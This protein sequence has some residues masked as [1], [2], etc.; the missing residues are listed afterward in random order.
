M[1]NTVSEITNDHPAPP[2]APDALVSLVTVEI[3]REMA[4]I[5]GA[6]D[7]SLSSI[8]AELHGTLG[9]LLS[10]LGSY[11]LEIRN[12]SSQMYGIQADHIEA[13]DVRVDTLEE[14]GGETQILPV[15]AELLQK[16]I[17]ACEYMASE[18]I[19]G[20]I[21]ERDAEGKEKLGE[22]LSLCGEAQKVVDDATLTFDADFPEALGED[23][24]LP[25]DVN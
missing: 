15:D 8:H 4:R 2:A 11:L 5:K 18:M 21:S 25:G 14:F 19:K 7:P 13:L 12:W 17:Q 10:T 16:V 9:S 23:A 1:T 20:P 3:P 24:Q 6:K 22:I